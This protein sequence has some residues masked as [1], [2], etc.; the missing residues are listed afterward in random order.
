[1]QRE[2]QRE[3][4]NAHGPVALAVGLATFN[5]ERGKEEGAAIDRALHQRPANVFD[6]VAP[7][8]QQGWNV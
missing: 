3:S 2:Y 6:A 1:L 4:A 7:K 8:C 5:M